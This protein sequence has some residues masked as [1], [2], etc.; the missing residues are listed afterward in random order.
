M[1]GMQTDEGLVDHRGVVVAELLEVELAELAVDAIFVATLPVLCE[2]RFDGLGA[3]EAGEAEAD[4]PKGVGDAPLANLVLRPIE[5]VSD[6]NLVVEQRDVLVES[7]VVKLLL[8]ERPAELVQ[9]QL[10]VF[11][12]R[13]PPGDGRIGLLRSEELLT[14][15]ELLGSSELHLVRVSRRRVRFEQSF[16]DRY[17]FVGP[18]QL[19][20]RASLLIKDRVVVLVGRIGF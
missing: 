15:E 6:R 16:D 9:G 1:Q 11:R 10:V 13:S 19:V 3:A 14:R 20:V 7:V 8:V 12:G 17:G 4:D 18:S 2:V 5:V